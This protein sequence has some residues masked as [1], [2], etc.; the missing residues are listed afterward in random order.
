MGQIV[1]DGSFRAF[2]PGKMR[3]VEHNHT[4][5]RGNVRALGTVGGDETGVAIVPRIPDQI[6][7]GIGDRHRGVF[8]QCSNEFGCRASPGDC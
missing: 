3:V 6:F 4:A 1:Q 2:P 5:F 7:D 8:L